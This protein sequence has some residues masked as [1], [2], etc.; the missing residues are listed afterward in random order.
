MNLPEELLEQM[1]ASD[2]DDLPDG[3]WQAVIEDAVI[4]YNKQHKTKFDPFEAWLTYIQSPFR[5]KKITD[6]HNK[7]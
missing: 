4:V 2:N 3:A 6:I 5:D 7:Q 1:W